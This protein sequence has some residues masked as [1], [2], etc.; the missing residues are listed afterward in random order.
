MWLCLLK[1]LIPE[2]QD[3]LNKLKNHVKRGV[4]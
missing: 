4:E 3:I 1:E 2:K